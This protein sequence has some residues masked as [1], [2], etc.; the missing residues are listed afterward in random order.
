[1][2]LSK[3]TQYALRALTQLAMHPDGG[4]VQARE[5]ARTEHIP[6]KF[7]EHI[8][9]LLTNAHILLSRRGVGGGYTLG[10]PADQIT[11]AEIIRL[12][13]G[14]LLLLNCADGRT[15]GCCSWA[16]SQEDCGLR[17]VMRD[18][19]AGFLEALEA[20]TLADV[21][22]RTEDLQRQKASTVLYA[23]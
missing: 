10:R 21:C 7:L 11:L 1:M 20:T 16:E 2:R 22:A 18:T 8:L 13:E 17:T 5:L 9:L 19:A 4:H 12:T 6:A 15:G 23:I 3:K 14:A